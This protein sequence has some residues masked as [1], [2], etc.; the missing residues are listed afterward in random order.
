MIEPAR[1]IL[2]FLC[3]AIFVNISYSK[4]LFK[5]DI[6]ICLTYLDPIFVCSISN[7]GTNS[8]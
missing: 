1:H 3:Y 2:T 8:N 4:H 5:L 7:V 6:D